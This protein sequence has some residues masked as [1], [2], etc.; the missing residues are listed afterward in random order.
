MVHVCDAIMGTGKSQSA[1]SYMNEHPDDKF[2][3]ITP[4][5]EEAARIRD[6]CKQ[7]NFIEPTNKLKKFNFKKTDHV[8]QLIKEGRNI[9]TTHQAFKRYRPEMLDDIRRQG[10]ILMIDE[11]VDVLEAAY[12]FPEDISAAQNCG[13]IEELNGMYHYTGKEYN[14]SIFREM[15]QFF[16]SRDLLKVETSGQ[17]AYYYWIL[18]PDMITSF[19]EVF[20]MTYLF[21]GQC[22]HHFFKMYNIDYDYI[23]IM[24]DGDS[25]HFCEAPGYVPEYVSHI[26]D[27]IHIVDATKLNEIGSKRTS[28][29]MSWFNRS[30]EGSDTLRKN[31]YNCI[32][33]LWKGVPSSKKLWGTFKSQEKN[34]RGKGYSKSFLIFNAKAMNGYRNKDHLIYTANIFM[35]V[36][37]KTLY[38]N[39]GITV[40]EDLYALSIMVQWIWRSAIRDGKD[41]YIYIPSSRMRTLL[42]E[43]MD[44]LNRQGE[45]T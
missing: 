34:L 24:R 44:G 7:M 23:G 32:N 28:L 13:Y 6:G 9:T 27:K 26:K 39:N 38:E 45:N 36:N 5:L 29:S 40:D 16:E 33:Y 18:P 15:I 11:N 8:A 19:K 2:I 3:Y 4:Y 42:I 25:F 20:V 30:D 14:G 21:E 31:M 43:W 41:I 1:I 37:D 17:D 35:N 10:Y 22:L 12:Y